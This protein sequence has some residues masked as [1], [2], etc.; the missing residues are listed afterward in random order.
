MLRILRIIANI[1]KL[2]IVKLRYPGADVVVNVERDGP[3]SNSFIPGK[4][5]IAR[6]KAGRARDQDL[7]TSDL[8]GG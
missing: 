7:L 8:P 1:G 5:D 4:K 2:A 3:I 6:L